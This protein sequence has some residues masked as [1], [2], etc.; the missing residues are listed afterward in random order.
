M[1]SKRKLQNRV[2]ERKQE[3]EA[4]IQKLTTQREKLTSFI[5]A[6]KSS[7]VIYGLIKNLSVFK[8]LEELISGSDPE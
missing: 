1:I 5:V 3:L 7:S 6:V 8:E 2:S 4:V